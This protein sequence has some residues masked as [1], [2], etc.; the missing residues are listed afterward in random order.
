MIYIN[1][2]E[3]VDGKPRLIEQAQF[4]GENIFGKINIDG[5][6]RKEVLDQFNRGYYRTSEI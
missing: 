6:S 5:I 4:N 1:K 2:L 3:I